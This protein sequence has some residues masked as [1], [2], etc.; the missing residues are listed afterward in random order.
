[1]LT[2]AD[3]ARGADVRLHGGRGERGARA[4]E[5]GKRPSDGSGVDT[6]HCCPLSLAHLT[7][8]APPM[9]AWG[10]HG[11]LRG[12]RRGLRL[13]H[14]FLRKDQDRAATLK[15]PVMGPQGGCNAERGAASLRKARPG[16][17]CDMTRWFHCGAHAPKN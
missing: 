3:V 6:R 11:G 12:R 8:Q 9:A 5:G 15:A 16:M 2:G 14:A 13:Q 1:M 7:F 10:T 4:P 17:T